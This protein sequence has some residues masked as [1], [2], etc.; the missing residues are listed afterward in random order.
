MRQ[1]IQGDLPAVKGGQVA[2]ELRGESVSGLMAGGRAQKDDIPGQAEHEK[3]GSNR[4]H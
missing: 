2:A 1:R 3:V 4:L